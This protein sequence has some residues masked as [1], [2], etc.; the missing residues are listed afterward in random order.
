MRI[1]VVEDEERVA[2]FVKRGLEEEHYAVD[3]AGDGQTGLEAA[4]AGEYDAILLDV[5][6]PMMNGLEVLREIR[7]RGIICPIMMLTVRGSVEDKV[8][9]LDAGADDYLPKPF[10]FA[11]L[12]ARVR[13]MT[14]RATTLQTSASPDILEAHG[15][16][17]DRP[18]RRVARDGAPLDLTSTEYN[19]LEL[20][21]AHPGQV[22]P[23]ARIAEDVW[24]YDF[25]VSTNIVDVYVNYLRKKVDRD[26]SRK[27][28]H[29]VRGVG[30]VLREDETEV[31]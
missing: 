25:A 15:L 12:L 13:A 26:F 22:L 23:R 21:L 8:D 14:R 1:L 3:V 20:F 29:T 10:A 17:M 28:I 19:L 2:A 9:G 27:L 16:R 11:E 7:A 6:M 5:L 18:Q 31:E 24:G 30:Y 4:C